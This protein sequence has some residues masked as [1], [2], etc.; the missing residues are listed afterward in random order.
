MQPNISDNTGE[1]CTSERTSCG[2][3]QISYKIS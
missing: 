2:H 1:K 3:L